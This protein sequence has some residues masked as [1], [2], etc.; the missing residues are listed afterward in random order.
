M[1][2]QMKDATAMTPDAT[3]FQNSTGFALEAH[4]GD[5]QFV[6]G[7]R[8]HEL[9]NEMH[10][11]PWTSNSMFSRSAKV[12]AMSRGSMGTTTRVLS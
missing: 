12:G 3:R 2:G 8:G 10:A 6:P 4:D 1:S 5:F 7:H 11:T 9:G